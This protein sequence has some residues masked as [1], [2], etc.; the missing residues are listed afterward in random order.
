M[1]ASTRFI[2]LTAAAL[3]FVAN[4]ASCGPDGASDA[5]DALPT[6]ATLQAV[7]V[8]PVRIGPFLATQSHLATV[9]PTSHV[10]IVARVPGTV[11]ALGPAEG[12]AVATG[13]QLL[14]IAAPDIAARQRRI[15]AERR[16]A[17][18]ERDFVCSQLEADRSLSASGDLP[19]LHAEQTE[20]GCDVAT[21]AVSAARAAEQEA[22]EQQD[23]STEEAPFDGVVVSYLVD[24]GQTVMPG[25]PLADFASERLELRL[26]VVVEDLQKMQ[27]GTEV[28]LPGEQRGTVTEVGL[29]AQ[30]PGRLYDVLIDIPED[31]PLR[32]GET[33][34]AR[35][36][37]DSLSDAS[38][39][40]DAAVRADTGGTY[41]LV[42]SEG[43]LERFDVTPILSADG[44]SAVEPMLA[45]GARVVTVGAANI[46][47]SNPV[48]AVTP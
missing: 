13:D 15:T 4:A 39:V 1:K 40:P 38:A 31:S 32:I 19:E 21:Q 30:G 42:E 37:T 25:T 12:A 27:V 11:S 24:A 48:F 44:W 18:L 14:S 9:A 2:A 46:D 26:R 20:K 36:V 8:E 33:V 10:R 29:R 5:A 16:R 17:V 22:A 3:M 7:R 41:V 23:K 35:V 34:M 45:A 43:S 28:V 6:A 47:T